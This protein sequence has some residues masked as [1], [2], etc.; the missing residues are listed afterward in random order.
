MFESDQYR[1][2]DFGAGE[3][4]ECWN[5][6]RVR[7]ATPSVDENSRRAAGGDWN[8]DLNFSLTAS[9]VGANKNPSWLGSPP[10][11][12]RVKHRGLEFLLKPTPAGQIGVFP[13]QAVNWDWIGGLPNDLTGLNAI[14]LFGYTGGTTMALANC[15]ANVT[16]VDAARNVVKWARAN[17]AA[18]GLAAAPIRWIVEDAMKFVQREF[19]RDSKYHI[20]VADPP[21]FGTG[22]N[23]E[24]WKFSN[25]IDELLEGLAQI[26]ARELT[27][28]LLSCHTPNYDELFLSERIQHHFRG[29]NLRSGKLE[30]FPLELVSESGKRLNSGHCCRWRS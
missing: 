30:A 28:V 15:G 22:P 4:L 11:E 17:A 13:E 14:N 26:A 27:L 3:K 1:L 12:W 21:S 5:G 8:S 25:Q 29:F 20:L 7:R 23:K 18:S 19:K 10:D 9:G 24:R 2:L 16:H 6:V